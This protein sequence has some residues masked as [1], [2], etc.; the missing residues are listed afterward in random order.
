MPPTCSAS[1][2]PSQFSR[3][4]VITITSHFLCGVSPLLASPL[5]TVSPC[6]DTVCVGGQ[7]EGDTIKMA[8]FKYNYSF[9]S[10]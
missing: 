9:V 7:N 10:G 4:P 8:L 1:F 2:A 6:S 5:T 3:F